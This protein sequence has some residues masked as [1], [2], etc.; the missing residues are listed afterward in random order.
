MSDKDVLT[1]EYTKAWA[2]FLVSLATELNYIECDHKGFKQTHKILKTKFFNYDTEK[3]IAYY[4][5]HFGICD[6]ELKNNFKETIKNLYKGD[7]D[8][9]NS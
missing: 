8:K 7:Y 4:K 6:C 3:S 1:E 5:K 2:H 9:R